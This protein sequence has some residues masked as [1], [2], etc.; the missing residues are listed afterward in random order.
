MKTLTEIMQSPLPSIRYQKRLLY[1]PNLDEV[2]AY[3]SLLNKHVFSNQMA[4]PEIELLP[5]LR[6]HWGVCFSR[7]DK[8]PCRE[9]YCKIRLINKWFCKQWLVMILAHELCHQYQWDIDRFV[10]HDEGKEPLMSHGPSFFKFKPLLAQHGI[11]L[12]RTYSINRWF[13]HQNVFRM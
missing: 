13:K 10:R 8:V 9:T 12:Y 11:P 6:N 7:Y 3:Y 4:V 1:R 5:R 2:M